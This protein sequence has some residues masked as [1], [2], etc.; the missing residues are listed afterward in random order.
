MP[1][2][3]VARLPMAKWSLRRYSAIWPTLAVEEFQQEDEQ[4]MSMS[5]SGRSL[6]RFRPG[7]MLTLTLILCTA[8]FAQVNAVYLE[9][10]IGQ[11]PGKNSVYAFKN[12]GTGKLSLIKGSPFQ[13]GGTGVFEMNSVFS[14]GFQADQQV[15]VN[16][17]GTLLFAVNGNSN[18]ITSF[19]INSDGSLT[20]LATAASNGQDP[21]SI[22]LDETSPAGPQITVVNQA[23]D[24][25]QTGGIPNITSFTVD[26]TTGILTPVANSTVNYPAGS[27]PAQALVSPSGKFN[28]V[29]QFMDGGLLSSYNVTAGGL[30]TLNNSMLPVRGPVFLG[31]Y[32]HPKQRVVY[33][34]MP[35]VNQMGVYTY[36]TA[37]Q[38]ALGKVIVNPGSLICWLTTDVAGNHLYTIETGTRTITVYDISGSNYL[39]P[40]QTQHVTLKAGTDE[41]TETRIDPTGQFLY[42]LG[43]Q[44]NGQTPGNF[45]HVLNISSVDGTL[46]EVQNPL[47][48]PVHVGEVP[49]GLAVVM[50]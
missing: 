20:N 6:S 44:P 41:P 33:V 15:V 24:P 32:A 38:L 2:G 50:K 9:S 11:L 35:A 21:V 28:F 23:D 27:L 29:V 46:T 12:D 16:S 48:I 25:L 45:L 19:G 26:L 47:K 40:I 1:A 8:A 49:Q 36:N 31:A 42:V 43:L 13:T 4:V 34:G 17:A 39:K 10:N 37:G 7:L 5:Q 22:G 14:P 3:Q 18:T 30:L